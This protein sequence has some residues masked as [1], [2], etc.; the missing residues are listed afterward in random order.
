MKKIT[1]RRGLL[2]TA[3]TLVLGFAVLT[4][5]LAAPQLQ[6]FTR[7]RMQLSQEEASQALQSPATI[8]ISPMFSSVINVEIWEHDKTDGVPAA[9]PPSAA[10]AILWYQNM[11]LDVLSALPRDH[12]ERNPSLSPCDIIVP[13]TEGSYR[14]TLVNQQGTEVDFAFNISEGPEIFENYLDFPMQFG[15]SDETLG[16]AWTTTNEYTLDELR[17]VEVFGQLAVGESREF[18]LEWQWPFYIDGDQDEVDTRLGQMSWVEGTFPCYQLQFNIRLEA[19][20]VVTRPP[21][22]TTQPPTTQPPTTTPPPPTQPD[23]PSIPWWLLPILVLPPAFMLALLPMLM[24]LPVGIITLIGLCAICRI[25]VC[26][27]CACVCERPCDVQA[28]Q[29]PTTTTTRPPAAQEGQTTRPAEPPT[30]EAGRRPGPT[31]RPPGTGDSA[32]LAMSALALLTLSG[33]LAVLLR[34]KRRNEQAESE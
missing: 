33:G 18:L 23:G 9:G 27:D 16:V 32:T 10:N 17:D 34:K 22:T 14:F 29:P 8:N 13:G 5:A 11:L 28:T 12:V 19:D 25:R 15:L 6:S 7:E 4:T 24:L 3:L 21:P 1:Q 26:C 20:P 2:F 30:T 31:V